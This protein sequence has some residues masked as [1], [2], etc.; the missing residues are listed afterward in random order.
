M[1]A[2][3]QHA[4]SFKA[5]IVSF[6][7]AVLIYVFVIAFIV[8]AGSDA[9]DSYEGL[10]SRETIAFTHSA[11][12]EAAHEAPQGS[13][14]NHQAQAT[15]DH[16]NHN[17]HEDGHKTDHSVSETSLASMG[18][19]GANALQPAPFDGLTEPYKDGP[20]PVI[21]KNNLT[22]FK[23]YKK[24]FT[25]NV[26]K[27]GIAIVIRDFGLSAASSGDA[28]KALPA[29]V[30]FVLSP[31]AKDVGG[32]AKKARADGH[33]IWQEL[34]METARFPIFDP[35][36][37]AILSAAGLKYNQEN[38]LWVLS[39]A[40]GYAGVA[41]FTDSAFNQS[42]STFDT[43]IQNLFGRGLGFFELNTDYRQQSRIGALAAGQPF[44]SNALA[45]DTDL[46]MEEQFLQL[47]SMARTR[48]LAAGAFPLT[49]KLTEAL[50]NFIKQAEQEGFEIIPLGTLADQP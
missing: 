43:V 3:L 33:E 14:I 44:E 23:A 38:L 15:T 7:L 25:R 34:P 22:P 21:G 29:S 1:S 47:Q 48:G 19:A 11:A 24:P 42:Q 46:S 18:R 30:T 35:G 37:R 49:P 16:S 36:A 20:L 8:M 40:A 27:P 12:H 50:Q 5:L 41:A 26:E 9:L 4:V 6:A 2:A 45:M 17:L 32:F 28:L 13:N 31:Y 39:R 10:L